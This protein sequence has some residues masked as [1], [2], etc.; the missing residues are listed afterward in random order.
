MVRLD[1]PTSTND[2]LS[3]E[4]IWKTILQHQI[5]I[6]GHTPKNK[7][8]TV[9]SDIAEI[10]KKMYLSRDRMMKQT[11]LTPAMEEGFDE[12]SYEFTSELVDALMILFN[13]NITPFST[14]LFQVIN[15]LTDIT[16][17]PNSIYYGDCSLASSMLNLA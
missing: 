1:V 9:L 6:L 3:N 4:G 5:L 12:S 7:K 10:L 8:G 13:D 17:G 2:G 11:L 15:K 16:V 14:S